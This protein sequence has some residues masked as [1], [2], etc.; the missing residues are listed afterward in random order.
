MDDEGECRVPTVSCI[1]LLFGSIPLLGGVYR[2][3][4]DSSKAFGYRYRQR[5][6][7]GPG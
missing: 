7:G 1:F 4:A 3:Y 5:S 6:L 2:C